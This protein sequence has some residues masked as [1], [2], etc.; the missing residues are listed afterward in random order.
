M[1]PRR[2]AVPLS[3]CGLIGRNPKA[4]WVKSSEIPRCVFASQQTPPPNFLWRSIAVRAAVQ[5]RM[6]RLTTKTLAAGHSLVAVRNETLRGLQAGLRRI[7][8]V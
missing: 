5:S 1:G 2:L 8:L 6:P 7:L 3:T 4:M